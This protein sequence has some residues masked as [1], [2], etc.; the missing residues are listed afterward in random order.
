MNALPESLTRYR[1]D[2]VGAIDRNLGRRRAV[3]RRRAAA[4]LVVATAAV[5][6]CAVTVTSPWRGGPDVLGRA[7]A[8]IA[9]PG[10]GQ[11]LR[12]R[13]TL[14][15]GVVPARTTFHI[16]VW[17]DGA[18]PHRYRATFDWPQRAEYGGILG[19]ASGLSYAT[20]DRVLDP[21]AFAAPIAQSD[22]DPAVFVRDAIASGRAT[23]EGK[24]RIAGRPVLR[25]LL[26]SDYSGAP[27]ARYF[28]DAATYRPVRIALLAGA[29]RDPYR[30]GFPIAALAF[31]AGRLV[32]QFHPTKGPYALVCDFDE[33]RIVPRTPASRRLPDIRAMHPGVPVI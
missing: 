27:I 29:A 1:A 23:V 9:V 2:L 25:I 11:I 3:R 31:A 18:S 30:V 8:A 28:V 32:I 6:A 5:A 4:A 7:T 13:I 15:S 14:R 33:Y 12:E 17:V 26:T 24:A 22:L 10:P 16:G 21:A 20:A 19:R